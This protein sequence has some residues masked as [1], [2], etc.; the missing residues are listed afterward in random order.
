MKD[1]TLKNMSIEIIT[2]A[3]ISSSFR[4]MSEI[5][6]LIKR[7]KKRIKVKKATIEEPNEIVV[8]NLSGR[9]LS[10]LVVEVINKWGKIKIITKP[11]PSIDLTNPVT[12]MENLINF[13][14]ATI[15]ELIKKDKVLNNLLLGKYIVIPPGLS[16]LSIVFTTMFH[17]ITGRFPNMSFF[18]K[19]GMAYNLIKP[20]DFQ[21]LRD[22][23]R[24]IEITENQEKDFVLLNLSGRYL[25]KEAKKEV[26]EWGNCNIIE[27]QVPN[28]DLSNPNTYMDN[29]IAFCDGIIKEL[30]EDDLLTQNLIIGTYSM[31]P[32]GLTSIAMVFCAIL[33]G[34]TGHFPIMSFLY[35]RDVVFSLTKQFDFHDLRTQFR[36]PP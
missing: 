23:Y 30:M 27:K 1:N 29:I 14:S 4:A 16:S 2:I 11:I 36:D 17:G 6:R 19:K 15:K 21:A 13:C 10:E 35:K 32:S 5:T 26:A 28:V 20:F 12:Y 8:I 34:I 31:V 24:S 22:K 7:F 9:P 3:A 33:H 18:Y 25:S